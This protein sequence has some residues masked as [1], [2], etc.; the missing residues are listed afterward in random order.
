MPDPFLGRERTGPGTLVVPF[1]S[2]HG[3]LKFCTRRDRCSV[4]F[5]ERD[6]QIDTSRVLKTQKWKNKHHKCIFSCHTRL[7]LRVCVSG[8]RLCNS[9]LSLKVTFPGG[10]GSVIACSLDM[11]LMWAYRCLI[12]TIQRGGGVGGVFFQFIRELP[13]LLWQHVATLE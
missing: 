2:A 11:L 5:M 9:S 7:L 1:I 10:A 12:L 13:V 4:S 3:T 8:R 6:A